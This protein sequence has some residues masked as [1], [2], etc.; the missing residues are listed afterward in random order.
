VRHHR[1]ARLN[2][3][4]INKEH[5]N[6]KKSSRSRAGDSADTRTAQVLNVVMSHPNR[7]FGY[8]SKTSHDAKLAEL[9]I[10]LGRLAEAIRDRARIEIMQ[11]RLVPV[12]AYTLGWLERVKPVAADPFALIT[13]ERRRQRE[14][15]RA[16]KFTLDVAHPTPD[17]TRK[18]RILTEE[19]GEV[20]EAIDRLE[21]C[22]KSAL[23]IRHSALVAELTQVCAVAVAWLESFEATAPDVAALV[24]ARKGGRA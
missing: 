24:T 1:R 9:S 3:A 19:L 20:A 4:T 15:L 14:L 22:P 2:A 5:M 6:T 10:G 12:A 17:E 11:D 13:A 23:R 21:G 18:L 8:D 7:I 16:G